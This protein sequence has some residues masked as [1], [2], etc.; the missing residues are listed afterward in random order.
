[1]VADFR[2]RFWISL[3]LT[4]PMLVLSP[5]I[6]G[7]L[8]WGDGPLFTG[9]GYVLLALAAAVYVYGGKP[10]T[11]GLY[12]ELKQGQPGMMTLIGLAISVA[13]FYSAAVVLGI[14]GK[15]FFWELAT[16]IDIM[17]LGHW[18]EMKSVMSASKALDELAKLMPTE[19]HRVKEDGSTETVR[20]DRLQKGDRI[21][22]KPG[23]KVPIDGRVTE[24]E[25]KVDESAVTGESRPVQKGPED[26]IIG[27]TMNHD[28]SLT[29]EVVKVGEETFISQ[30]IQTVRESQEKKSKSQNLADRAAFVLTVVAI[31]AGL[32]TLAAWLL[33]GSQF[34]TAM[35]RMVTVMV[36]TCPHA[37]G[38]AIPLVVSVYTALAAS[39]GL[40]I[41]N[42]NPFEDARR[43]DVIIF[44][45]TGTLTQGQFGV[46]RVV[47]L[48]D[49][50]DEQEVLRLAGALERESEH[51]LAQGIM[52]RVREEDFDLPEVQKFEAMKG[53][54][55]QGEVDGRTIMVVGPGYLDEQ[56]I[57]YD[58]S[59]LSEDYKHGRT[60][61]FVLDDNRLIGAVSLG[62]TVREESGPAIESLKQ[63]GVKPMM[64]TGDKEEVAAA[65]AETLGLDEYF[66]EVLPDDKANKVKEIQ[67]RGRRVAMTGD[68]VNDAPALAAADL[69]IAVGAGTDVAVETAD[70]VLVR[71]NPRDIADI[72]R[73]SKKTRGKM[74]Q[75]LFWATGYNVV[76]IPLAAGVLAPWG[77]I[78]SPALG[79]ALM[80]LS[81]VIVAINARLLKLDGPGPST[82]GQS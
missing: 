52:N 36:I 22:V 64:L 26:E 73:L 80:S 40:L 62:D 61:V 41:R 6:R 20:V 5:T 53:R 72:F 28:G 18:I 21:L 74:I 37:L 81:T 16:L 56:G 77:I 30:V 4:V 15:V 55:I 79:A 1:M 46:G 29:A 67:R 54:G 17:L 24:G 78:I 42:R 25:S 19:A 59:A 12:D 50:A 57:D 39:R 3:A 2:R 9:S 7:W 63:M 66:S 27:G 35:E 31:S 34:V 49:D 75:N 44:D 11:K 14:K 65:V 48:A 51:P 82:G 70:V 10:F 33:G 71:S 13:F 45:K 47:P 32:I 60:V 58:A 76:A 8:G 68:G 38:L 23:E 43:V 69:G